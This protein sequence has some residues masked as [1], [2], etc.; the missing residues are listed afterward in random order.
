ML[1][2]LEDADR[3]PQLKTLLANPYS[4]DPAGGRGG[5]DGLDS[6]LAHKDPDDGV[7][8][9]PFVMGA[10]NTRVVRRS[11][12]LLSY[13]YGHDFRYDETM[14]F[15]ADSTGFLLASTVSVVSA[16]FNAVSRVGAFRNMLAR[17][18]PQ[19]GEG[20]SRMAREAGFF[21]I[22]ML[23]YRGSEPNRSLRLI[24][25]GDRDPGYGATAKMLGESA[26]CLAKDSLAHDGGVLTPSVAMG[27]SLLERLVASAGVT[28]TL[29]D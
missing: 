17:L 16:L 13:L 10:I 4:L 25:R 20:P 9:A 24:I 8:T 22:E 12:A 2:M 3:D 26:V 14:A 18:L 15:A 29:V 6:E 19:P 23:A 27:D 11:N 28:F 7:W 5:L 21:E 1:N